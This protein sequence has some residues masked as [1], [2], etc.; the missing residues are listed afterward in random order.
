MDASIG[1]DVGP[2][3]TDTEYIYFTDLTNYTVSMEDMDLV[4]YSAILGKYVKPVIL[5]L[6]IFSNVF[7]VWLIMSTKLSKLAPMIYI[8]GIAIGDVGFLSFN[9]F[10]WIQLYFQFN[11]Y[12]TVGMCQLVNY[13]IK[14]FTFLTRW[15]MAAF[16]VERFIWEFL[17]EKRAEFCNPFKTKLV[18]VGI[19][20]VAIYSHVYLCWFLEASE[21]TH[22]KCGV[23]L[24]NVQIFNTLIRID[25][26]LAYLIP[27][28]MTMALA[29]SM[30]IN[31]LRCRRKQY[32]IENSGIR[33]V[34]SGKA[35]P[36]ITNSREES[37]KHMNVTGIC[38]G[39]SLS[40][41]C[42]TTPSNMK[43]FLGI[44]FSYL[45]IPNSWTPFLVA[46]LDLHITLK[47]LICLIVSPQVRHSAWQQIRALFK[48]VVARGNSRSNTISMQEVNFDEC[49]NIAFLATVKKE[50][51]QLGP[52]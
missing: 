35:R 52:A 6:G 4:M 14:A 42:L 34:N 10:T 1:E 33:P 5:T 13:G 8:T 25:M 15:Y 11:I 27:Y 44:M 22:F 17:P 3:I 31:K 48:R 49:P 51:E 16:C 45:V 18:L 40:L 41:L 20:V 30:V 50:E 28:C 26:V 32:D 37:P 38:L 24:D 19:A 12:H 46:M 23:H 39:Y 36:Q 7:L 21:D 47:P 43:T 9:V 29:V 2:N